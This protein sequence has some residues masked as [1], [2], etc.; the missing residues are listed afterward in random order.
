MSPSDSYVEAIT[1]QMKPLEHRIR[2]RVLP[3]YCPIQAPPPPPPC[4]DTVRRQ[5]SAS[6][7]KTSQQKPTMLIPQSWSS[8]PQNDESMNFHCLVHPVCNVLLW[9]PEQNMQLNE[10]HWPKSVPFLCAS[11]LEILVSWLWSL[12]TLSPPTGF[13]FPH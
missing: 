4:Q 3:S 9:Q 6:Q 5:P 7:G 2:M 1:S 11:A 13:P 10:N 8:G 12:I